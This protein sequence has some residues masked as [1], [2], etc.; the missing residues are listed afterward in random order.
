MGKRVFQKEERK[1]KK[2][3]CGLI[4]CLMLA[5]TVWAVGSAVSS[6]YFSSSANVVRGAGL[7]TGVLITTDGST[8]ATVIVY[9]SNTASGKVLFRA[10]VPGS[11]YFGGATWEIPI[12]FDTG[13]YVA[14]TTGNCIVY[15]NVGG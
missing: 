12:K 10:T 6:G 3:L 4:I 9:D 15:Y 11:A 5:S 1:M 7:L 2:V 8:A 14:V 13:I